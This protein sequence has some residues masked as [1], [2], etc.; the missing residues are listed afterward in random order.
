MTFRYTIGLD[1]QR[2]RVGGTVERE[3][4]ESLDLSNGMTIEIITASRAAPRGRAYA[5]AIV[6]EAAFLPTGDSANPDTDLLIAL[7]PALARVPGSLL[8]V[9]SSPYARRGVLWDAWR[10]HA[11]HPQPDVLLV[12]AGTLALNPT[13]D[14]RAIDRAREEDPAAAAAEYDAQFRSDVESFVAREV[15][16]AAVVPG[17]HELPPVPGVQYSAFCDPAGGSGADSFTLAIGHQ[18]R[19]RRRGRRSRAP[20]PLLAGGRGGEFADLLRSY[21]VRTV[22]G[23]RYAG[24]WPREAFRRHGISYEV[25]DRPKSDLYR[26]ALPLLN[27]GQVELLDVPRLAAQLCALER[28]T[29]RG[30]R[31]SI[32][33]APGGHDDLANVVLGLAATATKRPRRAGLLS[34]SADDERSFVLASRKVLEL[35]RAEQANRAR[36]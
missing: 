29:A 2:A 15:V 9:V 34:S 24:D 17:R 5:L 30:G 22:T 6:E 1:A 10:R 23:D 7:R 20:A 21:D 13:F 19:P 11:E 18:R 33:H 8:A 25:A 4:Q 27:S 36:D 35:L 12:Q 32:D 3:A 31:D 16:D 28:R 26:D 14:R